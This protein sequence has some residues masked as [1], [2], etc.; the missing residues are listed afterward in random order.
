MRYEQDACVLGEVA[1]GGNAEV[2]KALSTL[3]AEDANSAHVMRASGTEEKRMHFLVKNEGGGRR[4]VSEPLG[5]IV[6]AKEDSA[7]GRGGE[8]SAEA[9]REEGPVHAAVSGGMG[10]DACASD[11][12]EVALLLLPLAG[13]LTLLPARE[14]QRNRP[15]VHDR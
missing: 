2:E 15:R 5:V 13:A 4:M 14:G 8:L 6:V 1:V 3:G 7:T 11:W 9:G 12:R 10:G